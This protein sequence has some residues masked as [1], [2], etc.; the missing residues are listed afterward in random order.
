M[1][2]AKTPVP[3]GFHTVTPHLVLDNCGDAIEWYKQALGAE[4]KMRAVGPDG[5]IMH[6]ELRIGDSLIM[7]NDPM[8]GGKGPKALGGSPVSLWVY[9]ADCDTLFNRA[10]AAGAQAFGPMGEVQDQFWGD[11]SGTFTDPHGYQWT[12]ATHKEDL[13]P[14]EIQQRQ[15]EFFKRFAQTAH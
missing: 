6:A 5:K 11:R 4:E 9:V 13:T 12:I 10:I 3:E 1:A 15:E 8:M 7:V 2:T 14:Q